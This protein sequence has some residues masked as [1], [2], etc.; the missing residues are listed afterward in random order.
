M[1]NSDY[2]G[3]RNWETWN[4]QLWLDNDYAL[5]LR[6]VDFLKSSIDINADTVKDFV[7]DIF[8]AGTPDMEVKGEMSK[9]D[10]DEIADHWHLEREEYEPDPS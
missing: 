1:T 2:N 8:P 6:K 7:S 10:W 3:W 4:V 9:V 5:Y